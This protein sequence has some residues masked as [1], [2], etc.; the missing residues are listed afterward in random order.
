MIVRVV[1]IA[2]VSLLV[3]VAAALEAQQ[4]TPELKAKID[5]AAEQVLKTSGVPS[6]SVGVVQNGKILYTAAYGKARLDPPLAATP[7]MHY[8]IGSISKQFTTACVLLLAQDGKLT[9]D[10]PVS[11]WFPELT[12][13]NE[14][15]VR[16]LLTHTSGYSDYA[17][18][19]YTIPAWTRAANPLD[20]VHEW[21]EKPLDFTPGTKWQYS[22]TNF[23]LAGLIVQKASGMPFWQFLET[24]V[25]QPLGLKQVL[26]LDTDRAQ[27]EPL[28]YM[29]NALGPLRPAILEAPGWYFAD[30]ELSMPVAELLRWDISVMDQT[31]LKPESYTAFETEMK[32]ADGSGT[33]YGLGV[34]VGVRDGHRYVAHTGE[35]G[36][37]VAANAIYPD[38]KV[39]VAVLTNQEANSAASVIARAI[40]PLLLSSAVAANAQD[41]AAEVQT[42]AILAG[43]QKGKLDRSLFTPDCNFYFS[44]EAIEDFHTSLAPLGAVKS[45]SLRGSQLRGG[46][47]FKAYDVTF[48]NG[49]AVTVTTFTTTEGKIEQFLVESKS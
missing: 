8:A 47:T 27:M 3:F 29:R 46:M 40:A 17:P 12:R 4:I 36:G 42:R 16:N 5:A 38:D 24:R 32:L 35:V 26:N 43:L 18:Q 22:N 37:F 20:V 41:P 19:D 6:A 23:V 31:L 49:T 2:A 39:A 7:E 10:D 1:R 25:L 21:A 13:S 44:A 11:R 48:A 28:G 9:L 34:D 30:G 33:R 14:V 45:L 15:K